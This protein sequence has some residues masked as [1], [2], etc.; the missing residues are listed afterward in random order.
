VRGAEPNFVAHIHEK[1]SM[2]DKMGGGYSC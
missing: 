1:S 2:G